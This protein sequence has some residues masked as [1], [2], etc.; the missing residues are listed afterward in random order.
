MGKSSKIRAPVFH[1][2]T[3]AGKEGV[4]GVMG[5][6]RRRA[7]RQPNVIRTYVYNQRLG[8]NVSVLLCS[9]WVV[10]VIGGVQ[11]SPGPGYETDL[12][13]LGT[14]SVLFCSVLFR[15][16]SSVKRLSVVGGWRERGLGLVSGGGREGSAGKGQGKR[17][18]RKGWDGRKALAQST[19]M[20]R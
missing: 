4:S 12:S 7:A 14:P 17:L 11:L 10:V 1:I 3:P 19:E 20:F 13:F 6:R 8:T 2:V 16:G 5:T 18:G 9:V 15:M